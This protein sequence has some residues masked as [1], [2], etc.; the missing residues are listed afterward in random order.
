MALT[1]NFVIVLTHTPAGQMLLCVMVAPSG[2]SRGQ[3][4]TV[5]NI[6]GKKNPKKQQKKPR[7]QNS[8]NKTKGADK[9]KKRV[10]QEKQKQQ[11]DRWQ[12]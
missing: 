4:L 3:V 10:W 6:G 7:P 2:S 1:T 12:R 11:G 9:D 8:K 5:V